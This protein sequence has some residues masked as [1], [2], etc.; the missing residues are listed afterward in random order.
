[1]SLAAAQLPT[2]PEVLRAFAAR[3]QAEIATRDHEIYSKTLHI[4][5]LKAELALLKRG[6]YGRSSERIEQLEL[7]IGEFEENAAEQEAAPAGAPPASTNGRRSSP[8]PPRGRQPLPAHLPRELIEHAAACSCPACGGTRLSRIGADEREVL[9]YVPSS[10]KVV[11]H[12]RPKLSCRACETIVQPPMPSLPIERGRP[13]PALLARV[14]VGKYADHCPLYRQSAIY[15]RSGVE[16]DRSTLADWV[17]QSA[18]LLAPLAEAITRHVKAGVALHADDTPVP[19]LDPG[20]KKTTT[21]RLWTL[22]RD[23][24]P[25]NSAIPPAVSYLYSR[26][27]KSEHARR[28]LDGCSGY[29]HADGYAGFDQLYTPDPRTGRARLAEVA[30][31]AHARRKFFE[32]HASTASPLAL[33]AL[34]RIGQLFAIEA[35]SKGQDPVRRLAARQK[36]SRPLLDELRSF[37]E[38]A[39]AKIS[40]KSSLAGAIRYSLTRWTALCRYI[41]DGRLEISNNAAE[42]SIKP[43]ALGRKNWMFAGSDAG[44]RRA[45]TIYTILQTAALNGTDPEVYLRDVLT[46]IADHAIN[47]ID[48]LTPWNWTTGQAGA[49]STKKAA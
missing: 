30:C 11:V 4:E 40:K 5:K 26:D 2:D 13:G 44:G 22:V 8:S 19:V 20:R 21:G 12:V 29:L 38:R 37:L 45:A 48:E 14:L 9:E 17:G 33:E 28:L 7:L 24:R 10:F 32:V 27:R 46:R 23:E 39:L 43:L 6:R 1:M 18:A 31:F 47:R 36:R 3:L 35:E 49:T 15:A 42:R 25:W 41:E 16:L 34:E